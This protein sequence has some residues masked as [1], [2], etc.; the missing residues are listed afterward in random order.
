MN[1][2]KCLDP[3]TVTMWC[4]SSSSVIVN[5]IWCS[6]MLGAFA[7]TRSHINGCFG[8]GMGWVLF[9][10]SMRHFVLLLCMESAIQIESD[11]IRSARCRSEC[12]ES[13]AGGN[14]LSLFVKGDTL[15]RYHF[16]RL[17]NIFMGARLLSQNVLPPQKIY[18]FQTPGVRVEIHVVLPAVKLI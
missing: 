13:W 7:V 8:G 1:L 9:L 3:F 4:F 16:W 10:A 17:F 14:G 11:L 15:W 2:C 18:N 5:W 6:R 12:I